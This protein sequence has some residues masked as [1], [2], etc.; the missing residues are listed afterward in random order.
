MTFSVINPSGTLKIKFDF[1]KTSSKVV[2]L[3]IG[4]KEFVMVVRAFITFYMEHFGFNNTVNYTLLSF[5]KLTGFSKLGFI[6]IF[7][8]KMFFKKIVRKKLEK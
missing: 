5:T 7:D 4:R 8:I 1:L 2:S 3:T 6:N